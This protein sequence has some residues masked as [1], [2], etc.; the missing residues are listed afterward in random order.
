MKAIYGIS[1]SFLV[2]FIDTLKK[3]IQTEKPDSSDFEAYKNK[4]KCP[5]RTWDRTLDIN[6]SGP[7]S[8]EEIEDS[9]SMCR[10]VHVI[11][12]IPLDLD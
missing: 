6:K 3:K 11:R 1:P 8:D 7:T 2:I 10:S 5:T 12:Q 4:N 9:D